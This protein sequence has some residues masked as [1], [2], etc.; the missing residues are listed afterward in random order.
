MANKR[1]TLREIASRCGVSATM[2]SVVV[3]GREGRI[4]CSEGCRQRIL[5]TARALNYVPN[6]MA[7]SM[8]SQR[9]PV[10]AV[11][12]HTEESAFTP[13]GEPYF[14]QLFPGLTFR[15]NSHHLEALFVPYRND[16][17]QF[18]RLKA[19]VGSGFLGGVITNLIP[20]R[21][22]RLAAFLQESS[23]PYIVLGYPYP[24]DCHCTYSVT[25]SEKHLT[26][27]HRRH[28]TSQ[29]MLLTNVQGKL[30][31]FRYPFPQDYLW[32]VSPIEMNESLL[33]ASDTLFVCAGYEV[34]QSLPRKPRHVVIQE[35]EENA[36]LIPSH[37]DRLLLQSSRR[38]IIELAAQQMSE[39]MNTG[40]EPAIRQNRLLTTTRLFLS[41]EPLP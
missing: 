29:A 13:K 10:V 11:M 17:E 24:H 16:S 14:N 4:A 3:N 19:L 33:D 18:S 41:G 37:F 32:L 38:Q 9:S 6:I 15:L 7:R 34:W 26:E 20:H 27:L 40:Q 39:W 21:Y 8:V 31:G 36:S 2:V 12:L 35:S 5:A 22:D 1:V 30:Y 23:L 25:D 28:A